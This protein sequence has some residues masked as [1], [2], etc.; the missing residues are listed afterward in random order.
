[1]RICVF[2]AGSVGGYLAGY[3][4]QGGAEVSAVARG[5]HLAAIRADGL[6]VET[7]ATSLTVRIQASDA[8]GG[9]RP[10]ALGRDRGRSRDFGGLDAAIGRG[11]A[12]PIN[13]WE[14]VLICAAMF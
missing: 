9:L 11:C 12:A 10:A 2:G 8:L 3:L 5:A 7:P 6:T 4:A 1:M 14:L 13:S